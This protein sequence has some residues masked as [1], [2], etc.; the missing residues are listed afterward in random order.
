MGQLGADW[1]RVMHATI[2]LSLSSSHLVSKSLKIK[3]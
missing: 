3:M 2:Q 1:I